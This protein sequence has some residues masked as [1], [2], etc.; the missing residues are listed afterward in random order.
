[1][2][3]SSMRWKLLIAASLLATLV[4]AGLGLAATHWL[5]SLPVF[6]QAPAYAAALALLFPVAAIIYSA[7]FVY[8]HT[9]RRRTLQAMLM[10]LLAALLTLA[11]LTIGTMYLTRH[12]LPAPASPVNN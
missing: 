10:A 6:A 9:A 8:R 1:M 7:V 12:S 11:V 4:G 2:D 3:G 5:S